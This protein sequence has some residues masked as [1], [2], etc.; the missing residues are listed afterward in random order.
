MRTTLTLDDDAYK[1]ALTLAQISGKSLGKVVSQLILKGLQ[2]PAKRGATPVF[3]VAAG[4]QIIPGNR[5]HELLDEE[6]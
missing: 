1:S 3:P 5:I 6:L 2:E 4:T